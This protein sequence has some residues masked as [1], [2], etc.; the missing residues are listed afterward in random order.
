MANNELA[1]SKDTA[2]NL[3]SKKLEA[4]FNDMLEYQA[5]MF[6]NLDAG[7][8]DGIP[9][10]YFEDGEEHLVSHMIFEGKWNY[11][12]IIRRFP[13]LENTNE[14]KIISECIDMVKK[15]R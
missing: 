12:D 8:K 14:L 3:F 7:K 5:E 13:Y 1:N 4:V 10:I 15:T 11:D 6:D 9:D 2:Q